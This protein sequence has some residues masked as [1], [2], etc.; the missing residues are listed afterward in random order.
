MSNG[1]VALSVHQSIMRSVNRFMQYLVKKNGMSGLSL[2]FDIVDYVYG[3][4]HPSFT[5]A[6]ISGIMLVIV[7]MPPLLWTMFDLIGD[8]NEGLLDR[9]LVIGVQGIEV[10]VAVV[11]TQLILLAL[12]VFLMLTTI[13]WVFSM[14]FLGSFIHILLLVYLQGM[15]GIAFGILLSGVFDD[16]IYAAIGVSGFVFPSWLIS[17]VLWPR[18][19]VNRYI[20]PL[21]HTFPLTIPGNSLFSVINR[22]WGFEHFEVVKGY[23]SSIGFICSGFILGVFIFKK[24]TNS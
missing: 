10:I 17:G 1:I 23:L 14:P 7:I 3:N 9:S 18:M 2:P 13:F 11:V 21:S 22:G 15:V 4:D 24:F 8:K 16:F 19:T 5:S 20:K 12:F 6:I